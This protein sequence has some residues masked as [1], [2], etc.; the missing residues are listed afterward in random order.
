MSNVFKSLIGQLSARPT[1][2]SVYNGLASSNDAFAQYL[3]SQV[4]QN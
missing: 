3:L 2:A 4:F 1:Q